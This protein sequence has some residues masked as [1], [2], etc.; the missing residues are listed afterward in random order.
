MKNSLIS[1]IIPAYNASRFIKETVDSVLQQSY[2]EFELIIV[3]D[4]STDDTRQL[5][6]EMQSNDT[7]IKLIDK[8]NEGVCKA[9]ND[10]YKISRGEF[11]LFLDAD[12][13]LDQS[14]FDKCISVFHTSESIKAIFTK[15]QI[16]DQNSKRQDTCLEAKTIVNEMDMLEWKEGFMPTPSCTILRRTVVE[17]IGLWDPTFSTAADQDFFIRVSVFCSILA[18]DEVLFYYRVHPNNMHQNI[19]V[20]EK[21]HIGVFRKAEKNKL[22]K[23]KSFKNKC[24]S[25]LYRILAG[26]WWHDGNNKMKAIKFILLSIYYDF[27]IFPKLL[28]INIQK[29]ND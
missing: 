2:S 14:M 22:F 25:N 23:T 6:K 8:E 1:V 7:R 3:N 29:T 24:F 17:N 9:R 15:G 5:V 10:G 4:G 20:M 13:V 26:S 11:V 21:D 12:D 16:I 27:T 19:S 28:K 18:I